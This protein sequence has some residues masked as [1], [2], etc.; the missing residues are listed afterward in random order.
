MVYRIKNMV[1]DRCVATVA[2][3]LRTAGCDDARVSLGEAVTDTPVDR[4]A[5]AAALA[6]EGFE[7]LENPDD[8]AVE[9]IRRAV[10]GHIRQ[11]GGCRDNLSEHIARALGR[12]YKS[13]SALFSRHQGRTIEAFA[14][15]Q[16]IERVKELLADGQLSVKEI[17]WET[18]FSSPA[19]LSNRFKELTGMTPGEFRARG[20]RGRRP[21][22]K[23]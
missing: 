3:I 17:A 12:E 11:P 2:R 8:I 23:V 1:C 7:L 9:Q 16:R 21:L 5:L 22:D 20:A 15:A 6:A 19:H 18:G 4:G 10:I 13:L 14:N